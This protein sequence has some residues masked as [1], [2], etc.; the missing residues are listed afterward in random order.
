MA[1]RSISSTKVDWFRALSQPVTYLGVAM[2]ATI[3]VALVSLLAE[4]HKKAIRDATQD[5]D[6]LAGL[7]ER[8]VAQV[9]QSVDGTMLVLRRAIQSQPGDIDLAE[10]TSD[11][12]LKNDLTIQYSVVGADGRIRLSSLGP[13]GLGFDLS[14]RSH[15]RAHL[16]TTA[17]R[18]FISEPIVLRTTGVRTIVMSRRLTTA[19]GAFAGVL[20]A[21]FDIRKLDT[22]YKSIALGK[23]GIV[24]LIGTDGVVRG[25]GA[26]G[27]SRN[28]IIG[29]A[30]RN[31]GVIAA[32][33]KSPAG[34]YWNDVS[35][36]TNGR[37]DRISRLIAYRTVENLPLIAVVGISR[38]AAFE[39]AEKNARI[40]WTVAIIL[41]L[42][43]LIAIAV[44]TVRQRRL[45]SAARE[46][47]F[48]AY[49][50]GLT[51]LANRTSFRNTVER[52]LA[53]AR[54]SEGSFNVLLLDLDNFKLVNDTLGHYA[55][56][57]LIR[58]VAARLQSAVG[59]QDLVA[60]VGGDEF[61]IL[62]MT[63]PGQHEPGRTLAR[64]LMEVIRKPYDLD[65]HRTIVE[66]SI[67]I[68]VFRGGNV[69]ADQLV[70]NADLALYHAKSAGR[71]TFHLF[72]P[73][74][75]IDARQHYELENDLRHSISRNE[76]EVFY[77]PLVDAGTGDVRG[78][79]ALLRW[80]HP[81]RGAVSPAAFIPAAESTGL[82]L[83]LGEFVLR[84]ACRDAAQWPSDIKVAVNLSSVQFRRGDI[85]ATVIAALAESNL[86]PERLELE[87]TETV[88]LTK[89]E[90]NLVKLHALRDLGIS[91]ALDDFGTGYSS[92]SYLQT[93]PFDKLKID[94]SF[95]ADLTTRSDSAAI[96]CAITSLARILDIKVTA[97]GVET[98]EQLALLRAAGCNLAQGYL[99]G[100]PRPATDLTF[101]SK[102]DAA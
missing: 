34:H 14:D 78:L 3:A 1:T 46:V 31:S 74:M 88:L 89:D 76:F 29:R 62:Q 94:K 92:F 38:D 23:D 100:V 22:L 18:P 36:G 99:F 50:D 41:T 54:S 59:H 43:I 52:A 87:I 25:A 65:G 37:I 16:N 42:G 101:A 71:N 2:L 4:D 79:E 35:L 81:V 13:S 72:R 66:T 44:S 64:K 95:V 32:A 70:K 55:G 9:F 96:V 17:D 15:F 86:A 93:F 83:Q 67:G 58:Q 24:S 19:E 73:E 30:Y 47:E 8:S 60:R 77:Q 75:E 97:E 90:S 39:H 51:C 98:Q 57:E 84:Q 40:Y 61:A 82:I 53:K 102:A 48:L 12:Q 69:D 6:N 85:V 28:D 49:H 63:K 68:A 11:P 80:N 27:Q 7:L 56:D 10:W 5:A 33:A 21:S 45:L 91:I 26:N 20:T